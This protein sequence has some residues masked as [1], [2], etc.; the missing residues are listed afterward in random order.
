MRNASA[1]PEFEPSMV[2]PPEPSAQPAI[3]AL[4]TRQ[5]LAL[6]YGAASGLSALVLALP[7]IWELVEEVGSTNGGPGWLLIG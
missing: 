5:R 7:L 3:S 4:A 2:T 6:V 1:Q